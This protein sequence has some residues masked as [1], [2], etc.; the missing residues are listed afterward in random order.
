MQHCNK[1]LLN[2]HG[3]GVIEIDRADNSS[4]CKLTDNDPVLPDIQSLSYS[5][6]GKRFNATTWLTSPFKEPP[7]NDTLDV[8]QE[9]VEI[10]VSKTNLSLQ[11]YTKIRL[12][13]VINSPL[14]FEILNENSTTLANNQAH[15]IVYTYKKGDNELKVMEIWTVKENKVYKITYSALAQKYFDYMPIIQEM[16][17]SFEIVSSYDQQSTLIQNESDRKNFLIYE[18]SMINIIFP[19]NWDRKEIVNNESRK[20]VFSSP[21][22][23]KELDKASWHETT[24][25]MA[26]DIMSSHDAGTD[27]IITYSRIPPISIGN[28]TRQIQEVSAYNTLRILEE[29][30]FTSFYNNRKEGTEYIPFSFDLDKISSP[31]QYKVS[32]RIDD[33]FVKGH[34]FCHLRDTTNWDI[35]PAPEF[36]IS[37]TPRSV[38]LR[39][40]EAKNIELQVKGNLNLESRADLTT[41]NKYTNHINTDFIPNSIF[42][43][44]SGAGTAILSLKTSNTARPSLYEIT[45]YAN[46]SI[47]T[48]PTDIEPNS[49]MRFIKRF[50]LTVIVLPSDISQSFEGVRNVLNVLWKDYKDVL[51]VMIGIFLTPFG[52]WAFDKFVKKEK[53]RAKTMSLACKNLAPEKSALP[54]NC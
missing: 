5:S 26:V 13:S 36:S 38:V 9:E 1:I 48:I 18:D 46:I 19:F 32:F 29:N 49:T 33:Y 10:K 52:A 50:T 28:W 41:Y 40:G 12:A 51:I 15:K 25:T 14:S 43:P 30:N 4:E 37:A 31:E 2:T 34:R 45:I 20:I 27:Y 47:P 35:I 11:D 16:I 7:L 3:N 42:M 44:D 23:D 22:E 8:F 17:D 54:K 21:F 39:Q 24:F 53:K 6:D